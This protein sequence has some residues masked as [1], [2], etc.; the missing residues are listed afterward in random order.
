VRKDGFAR[1][2]ITYSR[3]E[4]FIVM[5]MIMIMMMIMMMIV[6]MMIMVVMMN[7]EYNV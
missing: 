4:I 1:K 7:D 5:I 2:V 3:R 6:M